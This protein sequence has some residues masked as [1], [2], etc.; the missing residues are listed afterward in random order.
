MFSPIYLLGHPTWVLAEQLCGSGPLQPRPASGGARPPAASPGVRRPRSWRQSLPG[1][2]ARSPRVAAPP[3]SLRWCRRRAWQ[4]SQARCRGQRRA[5]RRRQPRPTFFA[6]SRLGTAPS[7]LEN[8]PAL[9]RVTF[10]SKHVL[11]E[12]CAPTSVKS[13]ENRMQPGFMRLPID[14][15]FSIFCSKTALGSSTF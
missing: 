7:R 8:L 4:G 1:P 6:R 3:L 10:A 5:A 2:G 13:E 14:L 12:Q 9:P 11:E 15:Y